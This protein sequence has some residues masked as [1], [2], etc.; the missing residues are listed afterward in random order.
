MYCRETPSPEYQRLLA[1]YQGMHA[2]G[3]DRE[4]EGR[5]VPVRPEDAFPG[6]QLPKFIGPIK[7]LVEATGARTLID[8]GAGKGK[9]YELSPIRDERG[10]EVA[11]NIQELWGVR[12]ITL[13]DPGVPSHDRLPAGPFDGLVT[14]DVLEHVPRDDVFWVVEEMIGLAERFV[15]ANIACFPAIAR[16]PDG[17]NAH[18]T[19]EHPRWWLGVFESAV[20]RKPQ[21][22]YILNCVGEGLLPDG[23]RRLMPVNF[24]RGL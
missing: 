15:F 6:D 22:K 21:L 1:M 20:R 23:T 17:T 7:Q 9:Q 11:R 13:F 3:Y 5:K 18:V 16:L 14:T 19:V 24:T 10:Q 2:S 12:S 8:Y 4:V